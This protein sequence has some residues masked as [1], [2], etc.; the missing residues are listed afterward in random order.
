MSQNQQKIFNA[1]SHSVEIAAK[2]ILSNQVII[3]PTDTLYSFGADATNN[4]ALSEL[5][6]LKQRNSPLSILLSNI[7]DI[8]KYG[9]LNE[10]IIKKMDSLLPGPYTILLKSKNNTKISPIVQ[11]GSDKIGI[12]IIKNEFCNQLIDLVKRPIITT[13]VNKHGQPSL[14]DIDEIKQ[15]F[16]NHYIFHDKKK[17]I[18]KGSTIIDF[19]V[20]PE[21]I[22]RHGEGK[23]IHEIL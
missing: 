9:I 11:S 2:A 17:L 1:T 8:K 6:K 15:E 13:S 12:R 3:Y 16:K 5:N 10:N 23:Y 18:S 20:L 19:S 4:K 22:I 14:Y 7:N 21:K